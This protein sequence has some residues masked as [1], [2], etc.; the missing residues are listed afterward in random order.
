MVKLLNI[1]IVILIISCNKKPELI[2]VN[3]VKIEYRSSL[4]FGKTDVELEKYGDRV[5]Y[6]KTDYKL[7]ENKNVRTIENSCDITLK[8][9]EPLVQLIQ[10]ID[11]ENIIEHQEVKFMDGS[12]YTLIY[13]DGI[14]YKHLKI[15]NPE[16]IKH[17]N[18]ETG[19][20]LDT[21][22]IKVISEII[23]FC[24]E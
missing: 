18:I 23:N 19:F 7:D 17:N 2:E 24:N 14:N 16:S 15:Q 11:I 3:N 20:V 5:Y 6:H 13:G 12:Y 21:N 4:I 22:Y 9:F 8:E 10:S 1:L